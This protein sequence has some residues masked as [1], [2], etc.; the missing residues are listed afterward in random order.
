MDYHM[1]IEQATIAKTDFDFINVKNV[2]HGKVRDVY[3]LDDQLLMVATDRISA[4][5]HILPRAIP[6]KG[7]VL[8]QL[9]I[10][11]LKATSDIVPNWLQS[12]PDPNV[13]VGLKAEPI[14]IE[15]VIRGYLA[16][17][18]WRTYKSGSRLLCGVT[19]PEGL[20]ENDPFP[21]PI[22]TP[23]TKASAG[24]DMDISLEQILEQGIVSAETWD[25]LENYTR[26][27]FAKGS[28][29]AAQRGLILVDTKYE[30]GLV[31]GNVILIDEIHTPDSS[32]YFYQ[33]GYAER[34][35][36]SEAQPQLS[37]EFVREW[38]IANGFQGLEGQKMPDMP[39][40]FV[41]QISERYIHL[42]EMITG[43]AFIKADVS[44]I[45]QRMTQNLADYL[46]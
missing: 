39:D 22:I 20:K 8:N 10:H 29:M 26:T 34:Q 24:H 14:K 32:R 13:S 37:K 31:D 25:V 6:Y 43:H 1:T 3:D 46:V 28:E 38:L 2:Y 5:D 12:S 18:A 17:H 7:Q 33:D 21:I 40:D 45:H 15:M 44:N 11:F 41:W 30:F 16:G 35:A 27:L 19:M 23:T 4:F 9:A 42:Y 36:K